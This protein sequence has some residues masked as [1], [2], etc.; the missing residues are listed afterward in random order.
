MCVYKI[1]TGIVGLVCLVAIMA[2]SPQCLGHEDR[3]VRTDFTK[4]S[5]FGMT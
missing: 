3:T 2:F 4:G 5:S 1:E